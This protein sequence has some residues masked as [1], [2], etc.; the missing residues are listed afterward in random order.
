LPQQKTARAWVHGGNQGEASGISEGGDGACEG[1]D[2]VL[3]GLAEGLQGIAAE[4]GQLVEEEDAVVGETHFSRPGDAAAADE[5]G[6]G[7]RMV[8]RTEGTSG[9]EGLTGGKEAGDGIE[10][11]GLQGFVEG[12]GWQDGGEAAGE[13]GLARTR[14]P[15]QQHIV[16]ASGRHFQRPLHVRLPAHVA[17]LRFLL[18]LRGRLLPLGP[19]VGRPALVQQGDRLQQGSDRV[20]VDARHHRRLTCVGR[21]HHE[22]PLPRLLGADGDRQHPADRTDTAIQRQLAHDDQVRQARGLHLLGRSHQAQGD[23]QVEA[24]ALLADV[25]RGEIDRDPLG[26]EGEAG[27]LEGAADALAGFLD[28]GIGEAD[29]GEGI[30]LGVHHV[31]F[32]GDGVSVHAVDRAAVDGGE[33]G[34]PKS[35]ARECRSRQQHRGSCLP[36]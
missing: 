31:H 16:R 22:P 23:G 1:D 2:P 5:A 7:D 6:V 21:G 17:E 19:R 8:G 27:V 14:R 36:V 13:H 24:G 10:L 28:G 15:H 30:H 25:G 29:D 4:L 26:G 18:G 32:N 20:D 12:E 34:P 11:G 3:Q 35:D 33:H 9:E